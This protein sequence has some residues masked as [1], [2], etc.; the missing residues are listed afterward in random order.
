MEWALFAR[1]MLIGLTVAAPVGPMA[2]LC[3]RRTLAGGRVL[4]A[5]SG[6]GIATGDGLYSSVAAFG[7]TSIS[8][9][10]IAQRLWIGLLGG[11]L[12]CYLGLRTLR[13]PAAVITG[14]MVAAP[15]RGYAG[16]YATMFGLT[17]TNPPTI[18]LFAAIFAGLGAI[19]D[20][21][22]AVMLVGGVMVG[23]AAWWL[24]LAVGAGFLRGRLS[25]RA[26]NWVNRI[27]GMTILAF[28]ILALASVA[29]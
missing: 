19:E 26:M 13:S 21:A 3:I 6:L 28:G 18:L 15:A 17:L 2:V 4:G 1:G 29:R 10:L 23:S 14:G 20:G 24:L 5:V 9:F 25:H 11:A 7:L 16:A 12:L 8:G 22:A 27:S